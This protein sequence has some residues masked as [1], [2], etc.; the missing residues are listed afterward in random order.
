M[1]ERVTVA[2]VGAGIVGRAWATV[3]ARGGHE[4]RLFDEVP[5]NAA[6]ALEDVDGMLALLEAGGLITEGEHGEALSRVHPVSTLAEAL[7]D[8]G[9]V[10][11]CVPEIVEVKRAV[12]AAIAELAPDGAILASS[13]SG[14]VPSSFSAEAK[15]RERCLVAHPINPVHLHTL[16]EVVPA[17]WTSDD[18]VE[19]TIGLLSD[20]GLEPVRLSREIDGFLVNRLQSAVLHECFRLVHDGVATAADIDTAVRSGLAPRWSFMGPFETIDLNA[21]DGIADYVARYEPMYQRLAAGQTESVAWSTTLDSG[22][23]DER[24][25]DLSLEEL[26]VRRGWRDDELLA[27][28]KHRARGEGGS[29]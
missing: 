23:L 28:L 24:R 7:A 18:V 2:V 21:P 4:V 26:P 8:A 19:R 22:L 12:T 11:E 20:A 16:V 1:T 9:Y 25:T 5:G 3:L 14:M 27:F 17:P 6:K 10:Q 29:Q 15:G 13:T